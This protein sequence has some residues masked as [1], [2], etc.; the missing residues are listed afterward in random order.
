MRPTRRSRPASF[1]PHRPTDACRAGHQPDRSQPQRQ[2]GRAAR[3][4]RREVD[5]QAYVRLWPRRAD[6]VRDDAAEPEGLTGPGGVVA[7]DHRVQ[8]QPVDMQVPQHPARLGPRPARQATVGGQRQPGSAGPALAFPLLRLLRPLDRLRRVGGAALQRPSP[9]GRRAGR[10]H[11]VPTRAR[12]WG[13]P[14]SG[15]AAARVPGRPAGVSRPKRRHPLR[16]RAGATLWRRIEGRARRCGQCREGRLAVSLEC[17]RSCGCSSGPTT[18]TPSA[19]AGSCERMP[20]KP[21]SPRS[22]PRCR[23]PPRPPPCARIPSR[24]S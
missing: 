1:P 12:S 17:P 16:V 10:S 8:P 19:A 18:G 15:R 7:R 9:P 24:R 3:L 21:R 6:H 22:P 2:L 23:G 14:R 11:R 20:E 5:T 4:S 13:T